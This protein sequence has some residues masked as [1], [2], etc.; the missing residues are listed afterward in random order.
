MTQTVERDLNSIPFSEMTPEE[1]KRFILSQVMTSSEF[2]EVKKDKA[3]IEAANKEAEAARAKKLADE[4]DA[5]TLE[6]S[7]TLRSVIE[8]VQARAVAA[9]LQGYDI[10]IG[11]DG[12]VHVVPVSKA[13]KV[14]RTSTGGGHASGGSASPTS[15]KSKLGETPAELFEKYADEAA[16]AFYER[17]NNLSSEAFQFKRAIYIPAA[18][19]DGVDQDKLGKYSKKLA[20]EWA[21]QGAE[22]E[23]FKKYAAEADSRRK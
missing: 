13:T 4:R 8:K 3:A 14:A 20:E 6:V 21:A 23:T 7:G 10:R 5:I 22:G 12:T 11:D 17:I 15:V 9:E 19:A 1:K 2:V 18:V 16:K